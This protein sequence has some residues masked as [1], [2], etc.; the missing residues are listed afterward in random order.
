MST[1]IHGIDADGSVAAR[2]APVLGSAAGYSPS[3]P[4][5]GIAAGGIGYRLASSGGGIDTFGQNS[6]GG[7]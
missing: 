7:S 2:G 6:Y 5:I 1:P 3:G 4:V